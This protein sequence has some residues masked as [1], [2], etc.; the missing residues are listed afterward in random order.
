MNLFNH[1]L[2]TLVQ[3]EFV[4][5]GFLNSIPQELLHNLAGLRILENIL[6]CNNVELENF[7][8]TFLNFLPF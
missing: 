7:T 4:S 3:I 5:M 2:C 6:T 1:C 8:T